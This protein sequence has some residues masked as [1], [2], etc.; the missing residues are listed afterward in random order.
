MGALACPRTKG[1]GGF[2]PSSAEQE[3]T[4]RIYACPGIT[5]Y[6]SAIQEISG[7][8]GGGLAPSGGGAPVTEPADSGGGGEDSGGGGDEDEGGGGE[9]ESN[10]AYLY[11]S[12]YG[13]I[14][15]KSYSVGKV[16]Y[17]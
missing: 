15:R 1:I 4:L 17:Y 16:K 12:V 2:F 3:C 10:Y 5:M 13:R 8:S 14:N 9:S 7:W 11:R 6:C